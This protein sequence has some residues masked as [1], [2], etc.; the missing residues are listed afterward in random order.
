MSY[1]ESL[2]SLFTLSG[3]GMTPNYTSETGDVGLSAWK[4]ACLS[5]GVGSSCVSGDPKVRTLCPAGGSWPSLDL[6]GHAW[7]NLSLV[8]G[9][10]LIFS[11][12]SWWEKLSASEVQP[13][14][15]C[16]GSTLFHTKLTLHS[17]A[18]IIEVCR[19]Y[20]LD[21]SYFIHIFDVFF[22]LV[23]KINWFEFWSWIFF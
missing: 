17:E 9:S 8:Y 5:A 16:D 3:Y 4:H 7:S 12:I 6:K 1:Y 20:F 2:P 19:V 18:V 10:Q 14:R 11:K 21:L 23:S 13:E 22:N 15:R